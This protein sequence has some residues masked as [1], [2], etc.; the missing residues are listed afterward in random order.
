MHITK[1][2]GL[3]LNH[4]TKKLTLKFYQEVIEWIIFEYFLRC[5]YL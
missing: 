3:F 2:G 4:F 5:L 1:R